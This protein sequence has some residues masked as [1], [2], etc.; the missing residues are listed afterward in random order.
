ML[1]STSAL[2]LPC[3]DSCE[4]EHMDRFFVLVDY[5]PHFVFV[6]AA[7]GHSTDDT[8]R[9]IRK[10]CD[11]IGYPKQI[12]SDN[13]KELC[14]SKLKLFLRFRGCRITHGPALHPQF[15]GTG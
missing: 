12:L 6:T 5:F 14:D 3:W 9:Q 10:S 15:S 2:P 4:A 7:R 1:M 11:L 13:A 8:I